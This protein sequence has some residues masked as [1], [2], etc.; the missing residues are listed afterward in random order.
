MTRSGRPRAGQQRHR[1]LGG[2]RPGRLA[3]A[4]G[5]SAAACAGIAL[6][7]VSA[8]APGTGPARPTGAAAGTGAA[9]RTGPARQRGT[10]GTRP[11]AKVQPATPASHA[12][13]AGFWS[14]S[15]STGMP[16]HGHAPARLP[17]IGGID[18]GYIGMAGNWAT[19][20]G[21][22]TKEIWSH[23]DSAAANA[24]LTRYRKGVGTGVYWFMGGPGVDPDYNGTTRQAYAWGA[25]Q[26]AQTLR[27][28]ARK[29]TRVTYPVVFMDI[30]LPGHAPSF[31]PADDNGWTDVYTSPCSGRI[32]AHHI[33]HR[34]DRA[35]LDGFAAY[36]AGHS[37]DKAGVYSSP[38]IWSQIFGHGSAALIP[39]T[40]EWT[41]HDATSS[42]AR[43]PAGWCLSGTRT[44]ARFFG[45]VTAR[46]RYA[47]MWQ[48]SGGGGT[49]N[50][51]GDFDQIDGSRTP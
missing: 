26:A 20:Q 45:G 2:R 35:E 19:W 21:C 13:P 10:A 46:S 41:Y 7:V 32:S 37:A 24:S 23:E 29:T 12:F 51:I 14:G 39:H 49:W 28:I 22:G 30:E 5:L 27:E 44:C 34:I 36:L 9:E 16:V 11:A 17:G 50:G 4:I 38:A 6:A 31:T 15:D 18:G 33:A 48:W 43:Q 40:Y 25:A 47:L 8:V 3:A 42:L 1:K